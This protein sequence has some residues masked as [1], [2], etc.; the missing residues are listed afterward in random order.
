MRAVVRPG[1]RVAGEAKVP[2]DKSIAHRW[3]IFAASGQGRSELTGVPAALDIASTAR[4][5]G[6]L[7]GDEGL[8][9]WAAAAAAED[10][11]ER[12]TWNKSQPRNYKHEVHV[13]GKGRGGLSSV[14]GPLDCGN[15]GTTM[16]LLSGVAAG[17]DFRTILDGDEGLGARPMERVAEPLRLM[18]ADV[19]TSDGH[20]PLEITGGRLAG[21]G[22]APATPSSQVK[23]AVLLAGLA[24]SGDTTVEE[25]TGTRDHTE[26]FLRAVGGPV[27]IGQAS[28]TVSPWQ[29]P[30]F[31]ARL[32]GDPSSAAFVL[33]AAALTGGTVSISDVGLNPTRTHFVDVMRRMGVEVSTEETWESVGEPAGVVAATAGGSLRGTVVT[34]QEF[35]LVHDEVPLLAALATAADGETRFEGAGEL[36]V[37]ESNRLEGL[38]QGLRGLGADAEVQGD[39]LVVAGGGLAGGTADALR[40]H[41]L[42]MAFV[43]AGLSA[44]AECSI[45]GI[46]WTAITFPGFVAAMD[47]LGARMDVS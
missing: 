36:R 7:T 22:Y 45:E 47:A 29:H 33:A 4:C 18:G 35:P 5:M 3:L 19:T 37:K 27:E 12:H 25:S 17:C 14:S 46:E 20:A 43:V 24:A 1:G 10:E 16:R 32:P 31:A 39:A 8:S 40:D 2:G 42:A 41:R 6:S 26:R 9:S 11:G 34:A 15:S 28:V 23:G 44:R 13:E 30:G 38:A 21:I